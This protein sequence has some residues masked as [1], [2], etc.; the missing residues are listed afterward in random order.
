[1][2]AFMRDLPRRFPK[3]DAIVVVS[4]HWEEPSPT[5]TSGASPSLIY[6]YFGFPQPAYS[7]AYPSPGNPALAGRVADLF[8]R[9]GIGCR[10]DP[11]RGFDHGHF[12]PL[13]LMYPKSDIPSIQLS[14]AKG[15][16]P[17]AHLQ[18]GA[19]LR[20]LREENILFIGSGFSFHNM[21]AFSW[22]GDSGKDPGNDAFQDWLSETCAGALEYPQI[23]ARLEGW[24]K[25]P[26]ARYCHP[27][28]EH[29]LPLHVCAG[30]AGSSGEKIFDNYILGKRALAFQW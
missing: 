10:K 12:I 13:L 26:G 22:S 18:F 3:P 19:A 15:L 27:R 8:G 9:A 17:K 29:L 16:D 14:L 20:P 4:A 1:M 28:E 2:V 6:D 7:L 30:L 21:R 5:V 25:A 24:E 11:D 23:E